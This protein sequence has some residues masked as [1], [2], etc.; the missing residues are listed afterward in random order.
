MVN[1]ERLS[2]MLGGRHVGT[3]A[4]YK[5]YLT[6]FAYTTEWIE[7]GFPLNPFYMPLQKEVF[8]AKYDP[9]N[10]IQGIFADSLPDGWGRLLVDRMLLRNGE[11]PVTIGQLNRLALVGKSGMGALEYIPEIKWNAG[12]D[13]YSYD[14]LAEKC[15]KILASEEIEDL[16]AMVRMGGSSGG[17][18]PKVLV[19]VDGEEWMVKFPSS[20]DPDNIGRMEYEYARC[21]SHCGVEISETRLFDSEYCDGYFGVKRFDR[22]KLSDGQT[23]KVHMASASA[24]L[25]V[26]HRIPALDYNSL[27]A[28]TWQLTRNSIETEKMFRLMCFNVFVHNRDDHSK[29]F[30]FLCHDGRWTLA[31]AYDL[32]YSNSIGGEHATSVNGN[33]RDPDVK[34][35]LAVASKAGLNKTWAEETAKEIRE[36]VNAELSCYLKN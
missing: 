24:L 9:F 8:I 17:A 23:T 35:L 4:K 25:N 7:S 14:V 11:D 26:S 34:D 16:D 30:S 18:R 28:L 33:G 6:A 2:V 31:P 12:N 1:I 21:A 27:M 3:L 13:D 32:T 22:E 19:T 29:N 5:K 10:G 20:S 15:R 36:T